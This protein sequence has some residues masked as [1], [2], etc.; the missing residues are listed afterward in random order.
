MAKDVAK[1][2][3]VCFGGGSLVPKLLLENLKSDFRVVGVTSMV[4]NGGS[5]GQ[6]RRDFGVLPPGDI[7]RHMIALSD[8]PEW[9]KK[10]FAF[11]FGQEVFDGG[12]K[13]H[14]FANVFL[15]GLE[16]ATG[17]FGKALEE[18][19]KFLEIKDHRALPA[20]I[21]KITVCAEL[22]DGEIVVGEDEID[23]PK[24]H[25]PNKKIVKIYLDKPATA[26][27]AVVEELKSAKMITFGPGDFYSSVAPCLLPEGMA[28]AIQ[29]SKARKV[30]ICNTAQKL[31]ET[32]GFTVEKFTEEIEKYIGGPLD[33]VIYQTP[34]IS[35]DM[36][37]QIQQDSPEIIG[38][39][40]S[41]GGLDVNKF[42]GADVLAEGK[43]AYDPQK[44]KNIILELAQK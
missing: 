20:T 8:A 15:A 43:F 35:D 24:K 17:D 26:Y 3:I 14:R 39:V 32:Q 10:F 4:D 11:R 9:K 22:E 41:A 2:T 33:Y 21:D 6:L 13:G 38:A 23:V 42:I 36:I 37:A 30:L 34:A 29:E 44:V 18:A 31:G 7:V 27:L 16:W 12:H 25:D 28:Q 19:E 40:K 5:T 1:D